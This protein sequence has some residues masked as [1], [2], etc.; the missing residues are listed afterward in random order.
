MGA[1]GSQRGADWRRRRPSAPSAGRRRLPAGSR[2]RR[3]APS[4][5]PSAGSPRRR[6]SSP[7]R[8]R[9]EETRARDRR[10]TRGRPPALGRPRCPRPTSS[11]RPVVDARSR[12]P[13]PPPST[14]PSGRLTAIAVPSPGRPADARRRL[15]LAV[16]RACA[17][18]SAHR[19]R[20]RRTITEPG[21]ATSR[22]L[23]RVSLAETLGSLGIAD[24][25]PRHLIAA[26][27]AIAAL[28]FLLPWASVLAGSGLG[29][30]YWTRWGLAG[31]G[32]WVI[33]L[34]LLG[35][36]GLAVAS[37]RGGRLARV[38]IGPIAVVAAAHPG[39]AAV[40]VPVRGLRAVR[41]GLAR[42]RRDD[43]PRGRGPPRPAPSRS[44]G[45]VRLGRVR[46]G[47][48]NGPLLHCAGCRTAPRREGSTGRPVRRR[49]NG[50]RLQPHGPDLQRDRRR[51]HRV[52]QQRGRPARPP[53]DRRL[54]GHPLARRRLLGVPR[55]AA[56]HATTRSCR[57][58]RRAWIILFTPIFFIFAV[59]VY[60]IV[61]PHEKIGEVYERNLAEEAL[62]A[63][64]EAIQHCPTCARRIDDEWIICPTCR[65]RL[66]RVCPN[67]SRLVGLDWSL[68]AWCGKDFER[69]ASALAASTGGRPAPIT[70]L[71][72]ADRPDPP[73]PRRGPG[74]RGPGAQD[75]DATAPAAAA[76]PPPRAPRR[77]TSC[78]RDDGTGSR[79]VR[80]GTGTA[81]AGRHRPADDPIADRRTARS[82]PDGRIRLAG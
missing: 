26:G 65:T 40:A 15:P 62:L 29:G 8:R 55:H 36:V 49:P 59:L 27:S 52:L 45:A 14:R 60:R 70:P 24:D 82:T 11:P 23:P 77:P 2:V 54:P 39:R 50:G 69:P 13:L 53:G 81:S 48:A 76:A 12:S 37:G 16:G 35:L 22:R 74:V 4:S 63:E 34:A 47:A 68:C 32:H 61:R 58:S 38:P 75:R 43:R 7:G 66:N 6:R 33:V 21:G 78:R 25:V 79:R 42:P 44:G 1:A 30:T 46:T 31:P 56:A 51:R 71:P 19:R 10:R 67:C 80:S 57:T 9:S 72:A 20:P 73:R 18:G 41:R 28:G 3:A 17:T 5:P 64:V